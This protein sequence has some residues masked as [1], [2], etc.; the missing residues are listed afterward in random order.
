MITHKEKPGKVQLLLIILAAMLMVIAWWGVIQLENNSIIRKF[1]RKGQPFSY[2]G[3]IEAQNVPGV[4][5][6]HGFG[7]SQQLMLGFGN[8]FARSGYG[9]MLMDFKGHGANSNPMDST[10]SGLQE[11][12]EAATQLLIAQPEI[13]PDYIALLGHSMGSGA[14][15][16]AGIEN[17]DQYD[18][19]IAISPTGAEVSES[20]P[21]NLLLMA[22]EWES[23]F[24]ANAQ[25]LLEEA[26][27]PSANFKGKLA[28]KFVE[29]PN[30]EHISILF[31]MK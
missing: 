22:G 6:A 17:P 9:V 8:T 5:V 7:G 4:I 31:N 25:Q 11:D 29:I 2:I 18:A 26:G 3:P 28:R 20:V 30:V 23:R 14:V 12:I 1:E 21:P 10:R 15:M 27:G 24:V 13:N 19:V 16:Q